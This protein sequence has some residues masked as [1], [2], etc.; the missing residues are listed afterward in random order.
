MRPSA[1][2]I[3]PVVAVRNI[4]LVM[5]LLDSVLSEY[6]GPLG[7]V[8]DF[9]RGLKV[10]VGSVAFNPGSVGI[11]NGLKVKSARSKASFPLPVVAVLLLV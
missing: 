11:C 3:E 10:V 9:W 2:T 4:L 6:A 8:E 5:S 1:L 7:E